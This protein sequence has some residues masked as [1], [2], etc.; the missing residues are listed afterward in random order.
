MPRRALFGIKD[1]FTTVNALG[2]A[3]AICLCIDGKPFAA[4]CAILLGYI[5]DLLDGWVAR[6]L[7]TSNAFGAEYDTIS[8]HLS[9]VIAPGA[10]VYLVYRDAPLGLPPFATKVVAI[11]IAAAIMISASIRHA[12]NAVR[13]VR[14]K[15][16]WAGLPRTVLGMSA[17]GLAN[18]SLLPFVPGGWWLGAG[19]ILA[20]SAA[21]L[22][23]VP[24]PSHH[25]TRRHWPIVRLLVLAFIATTFVLA[26]VAPRYLF[27]V[28]FFW[29][30][31]YSGAAWI[32]ISADERRSYREA[33]VRAK[34]GTE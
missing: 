28:L 20:A 33:V 10:I 9:H 13:P 17:I 8:D 26:I 14:F 19:Y 15:G 1:L 25:L 5:G 29:M 27:D 18:S 3:V 21:T 31:G 16:V 34:E 23:H 24:Y 22:S 12:R 32:S 7:G 6:K 30:A 2:G 4:G 11:T